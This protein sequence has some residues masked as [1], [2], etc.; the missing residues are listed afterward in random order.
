MT[1]EVIVGQAIRSVHREDQP[2]SFQQSTTEW[3]R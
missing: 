2:P 1:G 3:V